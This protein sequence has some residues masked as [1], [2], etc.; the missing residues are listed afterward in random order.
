MLEDT[1]KLVYE[2]CQGN[3][4][5]LSVLKKLEW[6]SHWFEMMQYMKKIGLVGPNI[7]I[8][9]KDEYH[10]NIDKFAQD[11]EFQMMNDREFEHHFLQGHK[12]PR[13]NK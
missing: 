10:E 13:F 1:F 3:P 11:I 7:W 6:Y 2:V 12:F 8:K 4:G 9:Y 5:A